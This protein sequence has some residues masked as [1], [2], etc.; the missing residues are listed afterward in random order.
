M[1]HATSWTQ[2]HRYK[3]DS[4]IQ[5]TKRPLLGELYYIFKQL[6]SYGQTQ[7]FEV[8]LHFIFKEIPNNDTDIATIWRSK[9]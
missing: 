6:N 7:T 4:V 2:A 1:L 9:S 8:E 3:P 5:A